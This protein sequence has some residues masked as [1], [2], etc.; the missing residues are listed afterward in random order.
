MENRIY[1]YT[2]VS[3]REQH[4]DRGVTAIENFC[5][6]KGWKISEIFSDK[7]SGKTYERV[8]YNYMKE[9]ILRKGDILI[10]PE[11][12]RLGRADETKMELEHYKKKG[13]RIIFLDIPTTQMDLS[14]LDNNMSK[15][16]FECINDVLISV[17]DCMARTELERKKKRQR[18]GIQ[19]KKDRGEWGDY[20]RRRTM[21]LSEFRTH[22]ARV[23]LGEI[24]SNALCRELN[25]SSSTFYRYVKELRQYE[26]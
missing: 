24:G 7:I 6:S 17:F 9:K 8:S 22:Y 5:N 1:G 11:Y 13:V 20:G 10:I 12:D 16:I 23:I 18:E 19:A 25:M 14:N 21:A 15:M 4:L 3:T 2:R 26:N